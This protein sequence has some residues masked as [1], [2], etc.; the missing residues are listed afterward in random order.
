M[1]NNLRNEVSH[2]CGELVRGEHR[3]TWWA[4]LAAEAVGVLLLTNLL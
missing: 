3:A 4:V 1:L 2:V